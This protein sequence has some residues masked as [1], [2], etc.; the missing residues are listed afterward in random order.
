MN[1]T[2]SVHQGRKQSGEGQRLNPGGGDGGEVGTEN[3]HHF[4]LMKIQPG[5]QNSAECHEAQ[6]Q[7]KRA[8]KQL[9]V[10]P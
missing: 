5:S 10:S 1:P 2:E 4:S 3:S 7:T 6:V 9:S 8:K